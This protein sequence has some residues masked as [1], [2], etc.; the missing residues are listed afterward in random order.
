MLCATCGLTLTPPP[1]EGGAAPKVVLSASSDPIPLRCVG[2]AKV[3]CHVCQTVQAQTPEAGVTMAQVSTICPDC[4]DRLEVQGR[5]VEPRPEE[6]A[7][8]VSEERR[9]ELKQAY[10]DQQRAEEPRRRPPGLQ[11]LLDETTQPPVEIPPAPPDTG[12][13]GCV[14]APFFFLGALIGWGDGNWLGMLAGAVVGVVVASVIAVVV[15]GVISFF[16]RLLG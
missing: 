6:E 1:M 13:G 12:I 14:G 10:K 7:P 8:P 5:Q 4:G 9:R 11:R 3:V 2:C 16:R 15:E